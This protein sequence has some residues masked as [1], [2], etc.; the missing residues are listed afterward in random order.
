MGEIASKGDFSSEAVLAVLRRDARGESAS[1]RVARITAVT[2]PN[3]A[4]GM[5][6]ADLEKARKL[7]ASLSPE[8]AEKARLKNRELALAAINGVGKGISKSDL[9]K[10]DELGRDKM[11]AQ[12]V[13]ETMAA[14]MTVAN[15]G[16]DVT[17]LTGKWLPGGFW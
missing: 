3:S 11:L 9:L 13:A 6:L 7:K 10:A 2:D 5:Q 16:A 1:E 15:Y 4:L 14:G 12:P 8:Q 17:K